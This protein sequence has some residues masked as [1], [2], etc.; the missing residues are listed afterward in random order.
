MEH[1]QLQTPTPEPMPELVQ[2]VGCETSHALWSGGFYECWATMVV[3]ANDEQTILLT[4]CKDKRTARLAF[5]AAAR[6]LNGNLPSSNP[7]PSPR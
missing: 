6:V 5:N 4:C 2:V 3:D 7:T 1:I